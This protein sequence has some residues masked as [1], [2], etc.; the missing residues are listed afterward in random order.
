MQNVARALKGNPV[1]SLA[2]TALS[3]AVVLPAYNESQLLAATVESLP[4]FIDFIV[5]V[6]DCSTD[7][8]AMVAKS[9]TDPRVRLVRHVKW[10]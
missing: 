10:G 1:F 7:E 3:V 4:D 8:T 9:L 2:N 5:I 6:D